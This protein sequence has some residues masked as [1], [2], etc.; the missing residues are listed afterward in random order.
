MFMI[1]IPGGSNVLQ[2]KERVMTAY[3]TSF[4][5]FLKLW[6][7]TSKIQFI[8]SVTN[9]WYPFHSRTSSWIQEHFYESGSFLIES[10]ISLKI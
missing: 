6:D 7:I 8:V 9:W 3:Q 4:E 1:P 2:S 10:I 5:Y